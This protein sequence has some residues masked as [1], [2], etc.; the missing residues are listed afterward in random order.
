MN[1]LLAFVSTATT[2]AHVELH[3]V[4]EVGLVRWPEGE[5]RCWLLPIGRLDRADQGALRAGGFHRRH[6]QGNVFAGMPAEAVMQRDLQR[7]ASELAELTHERHLVGMGVASDADRLGRLM[8]SQNVAASW[9]S[10]LVDLGALLAG[11]LGARP[12]WCTEELSR[13]LGVDPEDF[14]RHASLGNCRWAAA[15]YVAW[16]AVV[17]TGE[18]G[19]EPFAVPAL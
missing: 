12:P 10:Q 13:R 18:L 2:G 15:A 3:E 1:P 8:R 11:H 6:P 7:F 14:D 5:E 16:L 4:W 9:D 19:A 17:G